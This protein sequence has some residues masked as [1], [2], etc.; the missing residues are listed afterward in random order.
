MGWPFDGDELEVRGGAGANASGDRPRLAEREPDSFQLNHLTPREIRIDFALCC[1]YVGCPDLTVKRE[2]IRLCRISEREAQRIV[3]EA[4]GL[5]GDGFEAPKKSLR[6]QS[7]AWYQSQLINPHCPLDLKFK[8]RQ[9]LDTLLGI[10]DPVKHDADD[11][12]E[13]SKLAAKIE[14]DE[15][16][17]ALES[18]PP[19][20]LKAL[21]H[22]HDAIRDAVK[23]RPDSTDS[24]AKSKKPP[25]AQT[26][27]KPA[28]VTDSV[29]DTASGLRSSTGFC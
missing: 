4:M 26:N 13:K 16:R 23:K 18:M 11:D 14:R 7:A 21:A 25:P 15:I 19:D 2:L 20:E 29:T 12:G 24:S 17:A 28:Y 27:S 10:R 1:I 5:M 22:A 8:A 3:K 6:Y 9:S